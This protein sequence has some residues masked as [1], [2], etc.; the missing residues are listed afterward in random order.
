[1]MLM[2]GSREINGAGSFGVRE[3]V[4]RGVCEM[5]RKTVKGEDYE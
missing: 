5:V 1:M 3:K 4:L 2:R